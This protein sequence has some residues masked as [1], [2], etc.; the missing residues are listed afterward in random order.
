M[1]TAERVVQLGDRLRTM[2]QSLSLEVNESRLMA[3]DALARILRDD[4]ELARSQPDAFSLRTTLWAVR[5]RERCLLA[6]SKD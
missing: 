1:G 2:A 3:H 4:P 5:W 6:A